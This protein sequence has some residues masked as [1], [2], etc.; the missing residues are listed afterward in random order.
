[1]AGKMR[2]T[3]PLEDY[4]KWALYSSEDGMTVDRP[5][6]SHEKPF[7]QARNGVRM[8][9]GPN[10]PGKVVF[11]QSSKK[12][13]AN[14]RMTS[15]RRRKQKLQEMGKPRLVRRGGAGARSPQKSPSK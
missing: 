7:E 9:M 10:S 1:M 12:D 8:F 3:N 5:F 13:D 2:F 6:A 11:Q 15:H 4:S 14:V